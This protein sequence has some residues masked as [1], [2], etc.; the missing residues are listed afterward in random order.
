MGLE[1]VFSN[2]P[3]KSLCPSYVIFRCHTTVVLTISQCYFL[4]YVLLFLTAPTLVNFVERLVTSTPTPCT[5]ATTTTIATSSKQ[6]II[7]GVPKEDTLKAE[8]L[9][10]LNMMESH[11]SF[12]SSEGTGKLSDLNFHL[13]HHFEIPRLCAAKYQ[14]PKFYLLQSQICMQRFVFVWFYVLQNDFTIKGGAEIWL[15][16]VCTLKTHIVTPTQIK[17][18][19]ISISFFFLY[20]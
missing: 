13:W 19:L 18:C 7:T 2:V 3:F 12:S 9:W 14:M 17:M 6:S 16:V 11:Y 15:C 10:C 1:G 5:P 8:V 4:Q 20:I